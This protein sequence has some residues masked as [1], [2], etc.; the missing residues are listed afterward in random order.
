MTTRIGTPYYI[1]PEVLCKNYGPKCDIWSTGIILYMMLAYRPPFSGDNEL[2]VMEKI[3]KT[4][5]SYKSSGLV[6][7]SA[8]CIDFLKR[9]IIKNPD[10]RPS[11]FEAYNH[12]WIQEHVKEASME[13]RSKT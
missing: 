12:P 13:F 10:K 5:P 7:A 9:M 11:A 6:N 8:N 2:E 3:I 1:A 4:E